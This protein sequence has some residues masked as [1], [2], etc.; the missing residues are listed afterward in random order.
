MSMGARLSSTQIGAANGRSWEP[1]RRRAQI[2]K[3]FTRTGRRFK[4][5]AAG[6]SN[7]IDASYTLPINSHNGTF[8]ISYG[9]NMLDVIEEPFDFFRNKGNSQYYELTLRQPVNP[10]SS[11]YPWPNLYKS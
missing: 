7:G 3:L 8:G 5:P 2:N 4:Q 6:M 11:I 1:S 10:K 9:F